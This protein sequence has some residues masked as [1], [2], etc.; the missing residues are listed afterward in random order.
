MSGTVDWSCDSECG[1]RFD[2]RVETKH[3][4]FGS[5]LMVKIYISPYSLD[6]KLLDILF[7]FFSL[8][9]LLR[10]IYPDNISTMGQKE[11]KI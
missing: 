11:R 9:T 4:Q 10:N 5:T 3:F 2:S 6:I 1:E 8:Y 7:N